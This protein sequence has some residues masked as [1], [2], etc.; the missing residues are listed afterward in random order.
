MKGNGVSIVRYLRR[1]S[2][3]I[4]VELYKVNNCEICDSIDALHLHHTENLNDMVRRCAEEL[5]I[6][7]YDNKKDYSKLDLI[8]MKDKLL[9]MEIKSCFV[10]LCSTCHRKEHIKLDVNLLSS[11]TSKATRHSIIHFEKERLIK[12]NNLIKHIEK[13]FPIIL[14][15]RIYL[16]NQLYDDI[17][18]LFNI[19]DRKGNLKKNLILVNEKMKELDVGFIISKFK[20][21]EYKVDGKLNKNYRKMY[22]TIQRKP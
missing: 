22:L 2:Q 19:R 7:F 4:L 21:E 9:G 5:G 1:R 12:D 20:D 16:D 17:Y 13:E 15:D 10:T 6:E 18:K 14:E 3:S 11:T 8:N